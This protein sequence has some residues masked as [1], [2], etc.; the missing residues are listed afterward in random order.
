MTADCRL[1]NGDC[2]MR[3]W[4]F[5]TANVDCAM[6]M[7]I[8]ECG[9]ACQRQLLQ[10]RLQRISSAVV[11]SGTTGAISQFQLPEQ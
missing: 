11:V 8:D 6:G 3:I 2:A 9:L 10:L 1:W 7:R 4:D 5:G